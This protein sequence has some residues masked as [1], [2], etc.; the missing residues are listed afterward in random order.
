[1]LWLQC[2]D[3][4]ERELHVVLEVHAVRK[5]GRLERNTHPAIKKGD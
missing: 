4:V 1:M 5:S 2:I 3:S